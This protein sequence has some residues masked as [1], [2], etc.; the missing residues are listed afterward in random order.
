MPLSGPVH[1]HASPNARLRVRGNRGAARGRPPGPCFI[2]TLPRVW[3]IGVSVCISYT[4]LVP[5]Q[6]PAPYHPGTLAGPRIQGHAFLHPS[7][8][9]A[10]SHC[11]DQ[12]NYGPRQPRH[13]FLPSPPGHGPHQRHRGCCRGVVVYTYDPVSR[14]N[15]HRQLHPLRMTSSI[16]IFPLHTNRFM[17]PHPFL[18]PQAR[19]FNDAVPDR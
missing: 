10:G 4:V 3:V 17:S 11:F 8:C 16:P 19:E 12:T 1:L 6:G 9:T 18:R 2:C 14:H 7:C 5:F 15:T 13:Y